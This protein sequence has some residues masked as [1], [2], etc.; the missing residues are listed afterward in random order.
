VR[1][2]TAAMLRE[3]GHAVHEAGSGGAA[4]DVLQNRPGIDLLLVDFAMPGMSGAELA[5][6]V[7]TI[8]P[9]LLTL[10][11]TGFADRT[12][13][14]GVRESHIIGKPFHHDELARKIAAALAEDES[15]EFVEPALGAVVLSSN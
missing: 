2:V 8:R 6:R 3:L 7:R 12:A 5:R 14:A 1:E 11:I 4:L 10:F 15:G 9:S 13:L